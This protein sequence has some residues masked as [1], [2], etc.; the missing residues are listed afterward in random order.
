M[1][2]LIT[3]VNVYG[4]N[5]EDRSRKEIISLIASACDCGAAYASTLYSKAKKMDLGTS[6]PAKKKAVTT[7]T[8]SKSST[9]TSF[10]RSNLKQLR[11][12]FQDAINAVAE[13]N[14]IKAD[15]GSIRFG[16]DEFT[17]KM[18]VETTGNK[19]AKIE[20][21][22]NGFGMDAFRVGLKE[23]SLGK[24]FKSNGRTFKITG[25]KTRRRSYPVS[26]VEVGGRGGSFKFAVKSTGMAA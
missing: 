14:G 16:D 4:A 10:N 25:V 7:T 18:T 12:E 3:A 17:V 9:V 23:D 5:V 1:S 20:K 26:A 22:K 21:A 11:K 24:T 15:F 2:K 19:A 13:R 6:A 8:S